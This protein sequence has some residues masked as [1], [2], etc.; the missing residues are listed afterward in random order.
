MEHTFRSGLREERPMVRR[1]SKFQYRETHYCR[2]APQSSTTSQLFP[3]PDP[4]RWH[5]FILTFEIST[6]NPAGTSFHHSSSNFPFVPMPFA[7]Y[8]RVSTRHTT[9]ARVRPATKI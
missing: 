2:V 4:P 1:S 9:T 7:T 8:S 3:R 6:R 5:I